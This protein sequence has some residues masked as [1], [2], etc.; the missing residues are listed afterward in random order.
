[1]LSPFS[2]AP[3]L[4]IR[5]PTLLELA[6]TESH[7]VAVTLSLWACLFCYHLMTCKKLQFPTMLPF[8]S[9]DIRRFNRILCIPRTYVFPAAFWPTH[10]PRM[11]SVRR[12]FRIAC[13]IV[14]TSCAVFSESLP[15]L[16]YRVRLSIQ[17]QNVSAFL[18]SVLDPQVK[19]T[20]PFS[21]HRFPCTLV[22]S[23]LLKSCC[24]FTSLHTSLLR[25]SLIKRC[26]S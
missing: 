25:I 6:C 13:T 1:M 12:I 18:Y 23:V 5:V 21:P 8:L 22:A 11:G 24:S 9:G 20:N 4:S 26:L 7:R 3:T 14:V 15:S 19:R 17:R 16:S 2:F 10:G